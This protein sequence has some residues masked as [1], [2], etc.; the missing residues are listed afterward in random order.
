MKEG[1]GIKYLKENLKEIKEIFDKHGIRYWLDWGTLL[2][3]VRDG[4]ILEWEHDI[5]F[6]TMND[7]WEKIVS[8]IPEL[9]ERGFDVE[10]EEHEIERGIG[11][12]RFGYLVDVSLY[13]IKGENA[14]GMTSE[15]TNL[16]SQGLRTLYYLLLFQRP[17]VKSKWK[18]VVKI[19]KCCLSLLPP[20]SR[21]PLSDVV[22]LA[23]RRSGVKFIP[24]VIPKHYFEK[25]ETIKFYG[26]TFNIPSDVEDYLRYKYG[27]DWKTPKKEWVWQKEDGAV[28]A[29]IARC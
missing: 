3:A 24:L 17:H 27:E 21:K 25:L 4:K 19:L 1:I 26:M 22:W 16:I 5:D 11:F 14:L 9:E 13:Q 6:G 2:G 7:S 12:Y 15:P 23:W 10:L 20:K 8:A 18:F 28:R 29:S